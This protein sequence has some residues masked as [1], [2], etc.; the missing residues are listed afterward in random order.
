MNTMNGTN[1]CQEIEA[2]QHHNAKTAFTSKINQTHLSKIRYVWCLVAIGLVGCGKNEGVKFRF[3]QVELVKQE[4]LNLDD[5]NHYSADYPEQVGD[6]LTALFGTPD[7][8][9]FP[10]LYEED[11][12]A[13]D[14][15]SLANLKMA[16]GPVKSGRQGEPAG[17]YREHCV[18]CHGITGDGSGPTAA[19]LN[20]YPRDFRLGKFKFKS[21]PLRRPPTDEDLT[22]TLSDGI[23]GT[24]MPSFRTLP[25]EQVDALVDYV[26]Y[27]SIRGQFERRLLTE[28]DNLDGDP[29]LDLQLISSETGNVSAAQR[30]QFVEQ[31]QT[32]LEDY[33]M[34]DIVERW[35]D[36]DDA[37]TD[38]PVPPASFVSSHPQHGD[39][40]ES[41]R[42]L[43]RGRANCVQCHGPT[44]LGDGQTEN[45]DDWTNDWMKTAGVDSNFPESYRR[46]L[47]AGA[48]KPRHIS[49]RNLQLSIF[50]GGSR[51]QDIYRRIANGI[52]GT[53]MPSAPTL[54]PDE[55]WALVAFVRNMRIE[56]NEM[57]ANAM[58]ANQMTANEMTANEVSNTP[59]DL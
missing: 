27:L 41:G 17:L 30:G 7:E 20:P 54:S 13:S 22:R 9:R 15:L 46:F 5:N 52:E 59:P 28:I 16:A 55:I 35:A 14:V 6:V 45:Y 43:F 40:I 36:A 11:D 34:E 44:G 47:N 10:F 53:P 51:P 38:V 32:L 8:P 24:A 29:L 56:A 1:A 12:P 57:E 39:L 33:L 19:F 23:P 37:V 58:E 49:P 31:L 2:V 4:R 21:T 3:N 26:K 42:Q 48:M 50:R 18:Q 25:S